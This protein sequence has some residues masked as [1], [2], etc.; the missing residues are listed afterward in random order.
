MAQLIPLFASAPL[1]RG[2][3]A[4]RPSQLAGPLAFSG[5][6]FLLYAAFGYPIFQRAVGLLAS[7]LW[8]LVLLVS[9]V[10]LSGPQ[11]GLVCILGLET[12]CWAID[13]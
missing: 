1:D 7:C 10:R 6:V 9:F 5:A 2:G 12:E 4:L 8:G 11:P 13:L 3:L